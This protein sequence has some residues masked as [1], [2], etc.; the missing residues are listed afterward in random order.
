MH[1]VEKWPNILYK[2][3]VVL[4][5]RFPKFIRQIFNVMREMVNW[6]RN[7][8][9]LL[10]VPY[11]LQMNPQL[12]FW[13]IFRPCWVSAF[14]VFVLDCS[15]DCH[16]QCSDLVPK[17]CSPDKKLVKRIFGIDLTTL[18]KAHDVRRP[19]I[20]DLCIKEIESRGLQEEGIYRVP[21]YAD[22]ITHLQNTADNGR[23]F[24]S[25]NA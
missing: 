7:Y 6:A 16:K 3:W 15:Y 24:R 23:C 12:I 22:D 25:H 14:L 21:G 2:S 4:A 11:T 18:I 10:I 17:S 13:C 8:N 5:A 1:N 19:E 9:V 20:V